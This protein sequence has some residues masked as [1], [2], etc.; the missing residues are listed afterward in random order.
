MPPVK[1]RLTVGCTQKILESPRDF[2]RD[3]AGDVD[4]RCREA[5]IGISDGGDWVSAVLEGGRSI[6]VRIMR[7]SKR[8][9][10]ILNMTGY[11]S[12]VRND[13][14]EISDNTSDGIIVEMLMGI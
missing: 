8:E 9:D 11:R 7:C 14:A 3:C 5:R 12:A 10:G 6:E 2:A 13:R 4:G 1:A